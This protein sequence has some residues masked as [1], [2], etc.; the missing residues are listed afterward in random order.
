ME[1]VPNDLVCFRQ[2]RLRLREVLRREYTSDFFGCQNSHWDHS[3]TVDRSYFHFSSFDD[4]V[5]RNNDDH[6][7]DVKRWSFLELYRRINPYLN[8]ST[9]RLR[10]L[11]SQISFLRC[12]IMAATNDLSK[13][14]ASAFVGATNISVLITDVDQARTPFDRI[15]NVTC[16][17]G[18]LNKVR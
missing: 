8:G 9:R 7:S 2:G 18:L 5:L 13:V 3:P 12:G 16:K 6:L 4:I 17:Q 10:L 1:S 11:D 15:Q 14:A